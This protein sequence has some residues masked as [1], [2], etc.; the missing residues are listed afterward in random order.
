MTALLLLLLTALSPVARAI[1]EQPRNFRGIRS[2]GMGGVL[3]TTGNYSESLFGNPARLSEVDTWKFTML[4]TM[5]E[6]NTNLIGSTSS[7]SNLKSASG[8]STI[9]G[10]SSLIGQ[11]EHL[12]FQMMTAYYDPT[13]IGDLGFAFGLYAGAHTNLTVNFTTDVDSQT[14]MDVGPNFGFSHP[15]FNNQ[16]S[17]GLN[18][19]FLYRVS[20]DSTLS[21][22]DFLTGKK[23]ALSNFGNQGFGVDADLGAYY[24]IPW[25][26]PWTR[27]SI[28]M[29]ISSLLKTHYSDL[30]AALMSGLGSRPTNNDRLIHW[31]VRFDFPDWWWFTAP[32]FSMEIQD[33]GDSQKR[34]SFAKKTH[35]GTEGKLSRVFSLRLGLNQGYPTAGLGIDLPV[36]KLDLSTYGEELTGNA[37]GLEDRRVALRLAFEL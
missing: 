25:E 6:L 24:H 3:Y 10:A 33:T 4:E 19:H 9:S 36:V 1:E 30:N 20:A 37:G 8:A 27:I 15:F 35:F 5:V 29:T 17:V 18:L 21:S 26:L 7:L 13:F 34:I 11:N 14:I 12:L 31:G 23:L 2:E 16:L 28:G 22:L 32:L